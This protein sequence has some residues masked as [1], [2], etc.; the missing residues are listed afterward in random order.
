MPQA[1]LIFLDTTDYGHPERAFFQ[2]PRTFGL[3][4]RHFGLKFF[5]AFGVFSAG[6]SAHLSMFS[7]IQPLQKPK[8]LYPIP[9][10]LSQIFIWEWDLN[11]GLKE[12]EI[13]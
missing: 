5:E 3:M 2:K 13:Y 10:Y 11:L 6:L 7:I 1:K 9:K 4:G 8:P 12:F